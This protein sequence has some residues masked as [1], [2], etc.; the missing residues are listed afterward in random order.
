MRIKIQY[1]EV[2]K[3]IEENNLDA[4]KAFF[5]VEREISPREFE[6]HFRLAAKLGTLAIVQCLFS[7]SPS[8]NLNDA[9]LRAIAG[10]RYFI[11]QYL[12]MQ[13]AKIDDKAVKEAVAVDSMPI[14]HY[15]MVHNPSLKCNINNYYLI[16]ANDGCLDVLQYLSKWIT[17]EGMLLKNILSDSSYLFR[18]HII[19]YLLNTPQ[20][21]LTEDHL[22][23][24]QA[25]EK[26]SI[27]SKDLDSVM[28]NVSSL[29]LDVSIRGY[30]RCNDIKE[31]FSEML[32]CSE[33]LPI[34]LLN[35]IC[36]KMMYLDSLDVI[37]ILTIK[38]QLRYD[39][40]G[41]GM[42]FSQSSASFYKFIEDNQVQQQL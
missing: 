6:Y 39:S 20:F 37:S 4:I 21:K 1:K 27:Y 15:L 16:A 9:F 18:H 10:K 23:R 22:E 25:C 29:A 40:P 30:A 3:Y 2:S 8:V 31:M 5:S 19:Y 38:P 41:K 12:H 35:I 17:P 26:Y 13:G 7:I 24:I 11:M 14:V 36:S 28:K 34:E 42:Y 32:Y 33:V